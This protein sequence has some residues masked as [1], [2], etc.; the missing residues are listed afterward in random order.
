MQREVVFEIDFTT[1]QVKMEAVNYQGK[2]CE[3]ASQPFVDAIGFVR[4]RTWKSCAWSQHATDE[5][6]I[7]IG[8]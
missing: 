7:E 5:R 2:D 3:K 4:E 6:Q 8:E 1:G